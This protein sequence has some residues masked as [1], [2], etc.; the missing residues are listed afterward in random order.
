MHAQRLRL[1][2]SPHARAHFGGLAWLGLAVLCLG[3]CLAKTRFHFGMRRRCAQWPV[4]AGGTEANDSLDAQSN[5]CFDAT[6]GL[7]HQHQPRHHLQPA[8]RGK[9]LGNP[10][11]TLLRQIWVT[12]L[13]LSGN[14]V[15]Q[16]VYTT[17][18]QEGGG[19]TVSGEKGTPPNSHKPVPWGCWLS[20]CH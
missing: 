12:A 1:F 19:V 14:A 10:E 8:H 7:R 4:F 9:A 16:A 18:Q 13:Q 11:R 17:H 3:T 20:M 6:Y 15:S 2:L 5:A